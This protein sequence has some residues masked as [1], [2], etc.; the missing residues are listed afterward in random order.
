MIGTEDAC[1]VAEQFGE[2]GDCLVELARL[3]S[4]CRQI[5]AAVESGLMVSTQVRSRVAHQPQSRGYR[6]RSVGH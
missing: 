4:P 1:L 6:E 3:G 5:V 2:H